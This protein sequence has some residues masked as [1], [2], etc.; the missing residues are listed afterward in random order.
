M[1]N[2]E[3]TN[4]TPVDMPIRYT[5]V[6]KNNP[7]KL[8]VITGKSR[9][10]RQESLAM[11]LG[12]WGGPWSNFD[13]SNPCG[14]DDY[15]AYFA[16]TYANYR[17]IRRHP[18]VAHVRGQVRNAIIAN[19]TKATIG[20]ANGAD[21]KAKQLIKDMFMTNNAQDIKSATYALDY[22]FKPFEQVWSTREGKKWLESK[23]LTV[24]RITHLVDEDG[25][26]AG[27]K[28]GS[29]PDEWLNRWECWYYA[30]EQ[31]DDEFYGQAR[32]ENIRMPWKLWLDY[33]T[34]IQLLGMKIS[35]KLAIITTPAGTFEDENGAE[36]SWEENAAKAGQAITDPLSS[37][38]VWI[39][40]IAVDD[41]PT[42]ENAA[43]AQA[44]FVKVDVKDFGDYSPALKGLLEQV[45]HMEELLSHGYLRSPR[46]NQ[47][48]KN[49]SR[50][51]AE[52]HTDTDSLDIE[53]V[54]ADI[55]TARN[56]AV[57][58]V[59][60]RNYGPKARG[61]VWV[62]PTPI[63]DELKTIFNKILDAGL[64]NPQTAPSLLTQ[65]G[66]TPIFDKLGVPKLTDDAK[67]E[68]DLVDDTGSGDENGQ[69]D[70]EPDP[71][72]PKEETE[73]ETE[74]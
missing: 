35:G 29:Q 73:A 23:P 67:V 56:K 44:S 27:V 41:I 71:E 54:Q 31:E 39:P 36:H 64:K 22:G 8:P 13:R 60:E 1:A 62:E 10:G 24:D 12:G 9:T 48:S 47:E 7:D 3:L 43:L 2:G 17:L 58:D 26:W 4:L 20:A 72:D 55:Y 37:N 18:V 21:E 34:K 66:W 69:D 30:H 11:Q 63:R 52:E 33:I 25:K 42:K 59:L 51:D 70:P 28:F 65:V 45:Q 68:L 6:T 74:D 50:A 14:F 19:A 61:S 32:L 40:S 46:T 49:G 38:W 15:G 53:M 57:D 16:G 5:S